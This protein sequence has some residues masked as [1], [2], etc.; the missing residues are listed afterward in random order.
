[1]S[2]TVT[3]DEKERIY[4]EFGKPPKRDEPLEV[5]RDNLVI[6]AAVGGPVYSVERG[7]VFGTGLTREDVAETRGMSTHSGAIE[8]AEHGEY[9]NVRYG[10]ATMETCYVPIEYVLE[11]E[12][13]ECEWSNEKRQHVPK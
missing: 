10:T 12:A 5:E 6:V 7:R 8:E 3:D 13:E 11:V 1:M 4:E 2:Y 9:V